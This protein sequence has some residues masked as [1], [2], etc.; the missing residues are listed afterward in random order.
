MSEMENGVLEERLFWM[1]LNDAGI[2]EIGYLMTMEQ[3]CKEL[4]NKPNTFEFGG[5]KKGGEWTPEEIRLL[6]SGSEKNS[7]VPVLEGGYSAKSTFT[8]HE[9]KSIEQLKK[10]LTWE[11]YDFADGYTAVSFDCDYPDFVPEKYRLSACVYGDEPGWT[12]E[13]LPKSGASNPTVEKY[14]KELG[15]GMVSGLRYEYTDEERAAIEISQMLQSGDLDL[16]M[17]LEILDSYNLEKPT[18]VASDIEW[19]IEMHDIFETM[20][21]IAIDKAAQ[22]LD[23]PVDRYANM[24]TSERYDYIYDTIRHNQKTS[25]LVEELFDLP[26]E[27]VLPDELKDT[28]DITDY[29]S[30]TYGFC[31]EGYTLSSKEPELA[32]EDIDR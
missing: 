31:I 32:K 22:I 8:V 21:E 6:L 11:N 30:D 5:I 25:F 7:A 13:N 28:D 1:N 9:V 29:I 3:L 4:P 20:D 10:L 17:F 12:S 16:S 18:L 23:I 2:D 27:I 15:L 14:A 26:E 24:T 19:D